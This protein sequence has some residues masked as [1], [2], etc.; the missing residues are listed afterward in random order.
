MKKFL[1]DLTTPKM[2]AD[3]G[4]IHISWDFPEF[5]QQKRSRIW[6]IVF[7]VILALLLFYAVWTSNFLFALILLLGGFIV[8][9][10]YFQ[11]ARKIP[12]VVG[13]DGLIVDTQFFSYKVLKSFSIVYEPPTI[14]YLYLDF[15]KAVRKS[16]PIP[17][18]DVNPLKV[19]EALL[20]YIDEDLEREEEDFDETFERILRLR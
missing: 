7:S 4:D 10:Q 1:I 6:Y 3:I 12:V 14:K 19:R 20:N 17:L 16:L 18:E 8:I 15:R 2:P 9:F 5:V 11:T 13:E